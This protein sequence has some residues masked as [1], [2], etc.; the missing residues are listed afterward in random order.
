MRENAFQIGEDETIF[1]ENSIEE[2]CRK[3]RGLVYNKSSN[4]ADP[5]A[6][7]GIKNCRKNGYTSKTGVSIKVVFILNY[8]RAYV[9]YTD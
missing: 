5:V 1:V 9:L 6:S 8:N 3:R 7:S 4:P 2:I